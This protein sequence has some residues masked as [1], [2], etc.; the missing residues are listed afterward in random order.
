[1]FLKPTY[2]ANDMTGQNF[3]FIPVLS[4]KVTGLF[5]MLKNG[6]KVMATPLNLILFE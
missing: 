2:L 1:M 6:V 3:D 5:R 4:N